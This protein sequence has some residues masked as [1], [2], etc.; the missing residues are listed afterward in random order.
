MLALEVLHTGG[1]EADVSEGG[2]EGLEF[3]IRQPFLQVG[4]SWADLA[5][6]RLTLIKLALTLSI[7]AILACL[8]CVG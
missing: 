4:A 2:R 3:G 5:S 1:G 6:L 8:A 7:A